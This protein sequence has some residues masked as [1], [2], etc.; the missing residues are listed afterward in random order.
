METTSMKD[1]LM[2]DDL[3]QIFSA[4]TEWIITK[5]KLK[6]TGP[7]ENRQRPML[8]MTSMEDDL[9]S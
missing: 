3:A 9:K 1:D 4:I 8:K 2:K 5:F 6:L 7:Q